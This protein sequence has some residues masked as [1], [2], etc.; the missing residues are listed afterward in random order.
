MIIKYSL[1]NQHKLQS[2]LESVNHIVSQDQS[3]TNIFIFVNWKKLQLYLK[4]F[5]HIVSQDQSV[6]KLM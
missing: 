5:E 2:Q 6:H 1:L 4:A 3:V